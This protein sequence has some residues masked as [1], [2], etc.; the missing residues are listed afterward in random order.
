MP[1]FKDIVAGEILRERIWT[2]AL[3]LAAVRAEFTM[4]S[5]LVDMLDLS[6]ARLN[7]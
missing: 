5:L 7:V 6:A 4:L 3:A 1:K 2:L